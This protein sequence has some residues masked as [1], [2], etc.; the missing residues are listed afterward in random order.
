MRENY[1]SIIQT[2]NLK[3]YIKET[4]L[5]KLQER[6]SNYEAITP[7]S[8]EFNEDEYDI[9]NNVDDSLNYSYQ[10]EYQGE[11]ED[12]FVVHKGEESFFR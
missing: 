11:A 5:E 8:K 12:S 3:L 6:L 9:A 10:Y 1:D 4:Q 2:T 7:L